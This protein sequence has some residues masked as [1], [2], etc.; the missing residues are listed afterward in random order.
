MTVR[1]PLMRPPSVKKEKRPEPK[2]AKDRT[3]AA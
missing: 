3:K 2:S 1:R